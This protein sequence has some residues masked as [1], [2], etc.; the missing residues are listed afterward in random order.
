MISYEVAMGLALVAVFMYAGS[1]STS[2]I[3]EAQKDLW[4]AVILV[5]SFVIY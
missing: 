5:P 4:F 3:V 1:M 2:E